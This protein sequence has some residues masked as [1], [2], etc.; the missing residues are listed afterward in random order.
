MSAAPFGREWNAL[1]DYPVEKAAKLYVSYARQIGATQAAMNYLG[2]LTTVTK[3]DITMATAKKTA[4]TD[5]PKTTPAAKGSLKGKGPANEAAAL[6]A[7]VKTG[8]KKGDLPANSVPKQKPGKA[9]NPKAGAKK[10]V[11]KK[12]AAKAGKAKAEKAPSNR[13]PS[14]SSRFQEL[15]REGKLTDDQIFAKVQKEFSLDDK[16]RSYVSWY[17][18]HMRKNGEKVPDAKA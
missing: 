7:S 10:A 9:A 3:E 18:N 14:A 4:K 5:K 6:D 12:P 13:G 17:R 15:I 1:V 2:E 11:A 16:K 8:T